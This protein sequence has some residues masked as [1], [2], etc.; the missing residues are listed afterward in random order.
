MHPIQPSAERMVAP[1]VV[2][3]AEEARVRFEVVLSEQ[4]Q[5]VDGVGDTVRMLFGL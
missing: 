4:S 2:V 5:W 3:V 1:L